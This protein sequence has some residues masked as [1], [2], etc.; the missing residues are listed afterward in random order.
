MRQNDYHDL[1]SVVIQISNN[2]MNHIVVSIKYAYIIV[3]SVN[4]KNIYY[5][6]I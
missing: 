2:I 5:F 4:I 1:P 3:Y 6:D